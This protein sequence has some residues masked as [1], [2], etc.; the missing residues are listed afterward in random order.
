MIAPGS[1]VRVY[2]LLLDGRTGSLLVL[3]RVVNGRP[4]C[5]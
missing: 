2:L 5:H 4:F 3:T 1:G